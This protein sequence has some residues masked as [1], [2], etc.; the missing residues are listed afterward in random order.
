M[1]RPLP[2]LSGNDGKPFSIVIDKF[3]KGTMTL[4]DETRLPQDAVQRALNMYL[5]QDG[6]WT[7]RPGTT[8]YGA[9]LTTPIDG[10][11]SYAKYNSDGSISDLSVVSDDEV[12]RV[13]N[14]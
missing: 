3:G 5:D 4:F 6:V 12:K 8:T 13:A 1:A 10:A 9:T 11:T 2:K 7:T 14:L